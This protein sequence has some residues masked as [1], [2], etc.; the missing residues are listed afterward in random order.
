MAEMGSF[1]ELQFQKGKEYFKGDN[2]VRLNSGR[3]AIFHSIR[4]FACNIAYV[5]YYECDTVRNFLIKKGIKVFYYHIDNNFNPILEKNDEHS[6][7]VI[8]NYFGIMSSSR[9]EELA[10]RYQNVIID[11]AQAFFS[12]PIANCM[13]VYSAR[14]FFG[15][16]DGAYVIGKEI[17]HYYDEYDQDFSSDTSLFLLQRIEYG[18][19]GKAYQSRMINEKRIDGSEVKRMSKLTQTI[20]DGIDYISIKKKRKENF[21]YACELFNERNIFNPLQYF[22]NDTV[23][24]VYPLVIEDD[25][26]LPK[27]LQAKHF[28]GHLWSYL[29]DEVEKDSF[30]YWISRY[31]IPITIDQRYGK[32]GLVKI[33][34]VI[35]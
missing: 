1:I 4:C 29:L 16:S 8:P 17:N 5:P 6:A 22:D 2:V 19:E 25:L 20:L 34:E 26:L 30:E 7:I 33:Q 14:K 12:E 11:N 15:V 10:S 35:G 3:A 13:N 21:L 32:K 18:C 24:M 28:Q 27:L 9:M 23:P 31:I